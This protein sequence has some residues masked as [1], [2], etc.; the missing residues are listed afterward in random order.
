MD[1]GEPGSIKQ[2][3]FCMQF[4]VTFSLIQRE[5]WVVLASLCDGP[6]L[7]WTDQALFPTGATRVENTSISN[8]VMKWKAVNGKELRLKLSFKRVNCVCSD[9]LIFM[10]DMIRAVEHSVMNK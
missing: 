7:S 6:V 5:Q 2:P 9:A 8:T 4:D 10:A 3:S 1:V